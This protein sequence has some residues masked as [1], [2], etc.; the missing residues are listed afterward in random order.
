M[1]AIAIKEDNGEKRKERSKEMKKW[2]NS[3]PE[4]FGEERNRS[5]RSRDKKVEENL[6]KVRIN[7]IKETISQR[8]KSKEA[9]VGQNKGENEGVKEVKKELGERIKSRIGKD[10]NE[11]IMKKKDGNR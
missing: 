1:L 9:K 8:R 2:S 3:Q 7:K 5:N 10:S 4:E 6:V 11:D